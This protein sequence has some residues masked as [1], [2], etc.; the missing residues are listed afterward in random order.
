MHSDFQAASY[1]FCL[2]NQSVT[3]VTDFSAL[4]L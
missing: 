2:F 3:G 4:R 1:S